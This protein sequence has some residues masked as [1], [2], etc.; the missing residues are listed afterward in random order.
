MLSREGR[1]GGLENAVCQQI[2]L[3][4]Y[5]LGWGTSCPDHRPVAAAVLALAHAARQIADLIARGSLAGPLG[6]EV[7][8]NVDADV[9]KELYVRANALL[10]AALQTTPVAA[11]ASEEL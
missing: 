7:G 2:S 4:T 10:I 1:L 9:Q 11:I 3:E 8:T 5:L 6:A